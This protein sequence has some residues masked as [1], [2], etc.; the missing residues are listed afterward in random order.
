MGPTAARPTLV[1]CSVDGLAFRTRGSRLRRIRSV[2]SRTRDRGGA[3]FLPPR[4]TVA[5]VGRCVCWAPTSS[6]AGCATS[7]LLEANGGSAA[8]GDSAAVM[9]A[10]EIADAANSGTVLDA[11][12]SS[13]PVESGAEAG[14]SAALFSDPVVSVAIGG[15]R[16][17]SGCGRG[18]GLGRT[19]AADSGEG[20]AVGGDAAGA[21]TAMVTRAGVTGRPSSSS[22]SSSRSASATP[23]CDPGEI[24]SMAGDVGRSPLRRRRPPRRPRRRARAAPSAVTAAPSAASALGAVA[25]TGDGAAGTAVTVAV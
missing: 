8:A 23:G 24:E 10:P 9:A 12:A 2:A 11:G 17:T 7:L 1:P 5:Q 4:R 21:S 25:A 15:C 22:A 16:R 19:P 6:D 3:Q 18:C 13:C 20:E 14:A